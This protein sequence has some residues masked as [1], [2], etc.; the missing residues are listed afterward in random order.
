MFE[1]ICLSAWQVTRLIRANMIVVH[2]QDFLQLG[3]Q[4]VD[5][6]KL[7]SLVLLTIHFMGCGLFVV[8]NLEASSSPLPPLSWEDENGLRGESALTRYWAGIYW[9]TMTATTIGFGE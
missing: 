2:V 4:A 8:S 1:Y 7:C 9:A 3:S 6:F 5:L